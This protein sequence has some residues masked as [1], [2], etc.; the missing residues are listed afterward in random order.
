M[1][2]GSSVVHAWKQYNMQIPQSEKSVVML[3]SLFTIIYQSLHRTKSSTQFGRQ[4]TVTV[5]VDVNV[6][7]F[8]YV[9]FTAC[10]SPR[11]Q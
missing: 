3:T 6:N 2:M 5:T 1:R 9:R 10:F 11:T 4:L 7:T 8:T